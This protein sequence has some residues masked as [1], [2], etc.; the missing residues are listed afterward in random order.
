MS[1]YAADLQPLPSSHGMGDFLDKQLHSLQCNPCIS[2]E[3]H[4]A[5]IHSHKSVTIAC[6][7]RTYA[8]CQSD[9]AQTFL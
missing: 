4:S 8:N 1:G 3:D 7:H 2:H 6:W 9:Q 5:A